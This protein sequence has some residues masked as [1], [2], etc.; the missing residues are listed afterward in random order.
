MGH[1]GDRAGGGVIP[2]RRAKA[3]KGGDE[4]HSAAVGD[5]LGQIGQAG[6]VLDPQKPR[7][8]GGGLGRDGD[9]AL[10]RVGGAGAV[11]PGDGAGKPVM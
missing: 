4:N 3:C 1:A 9:V 6:G 11:G 10:Q 8:E 2:V 5:G 7:H